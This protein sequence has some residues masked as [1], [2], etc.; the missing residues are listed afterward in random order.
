MTEFF[1]ATVNGLTTG[2]V[3]F[4]VAVGLTLVFGIGGVLN[5][6]HGAVFA[7]GAYVM[8][9]VLSRNESTMVMF[10]LAA[11]AA[12]LVAGLL[13]LVAE[14]LI[15]RRMYHLRHEYML[16]GTYALLLILDG[17]IELIWGPNPHS[18]TAP[19]ALRGAVTVPGV[20]INVPIFS[21]F[22]IVVALLTLL[23]L[24]WWMQ[25]TSF[26]RIAKAA[27]QDREATLALGV[28]VP[29]VM[30]GIFVLGSVLAGLAGAALAPN[31]AIFPALGHLFIIQAFAAIVMGG[32]GSVIGSWVAAVIL[33]L[34]DAYWFVL[35]PGVPQI[36]IFVALV[37]V[38]I[39]RPTGLMGAKS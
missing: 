24:Y 25:R 4:L 17:T 23:G 9:A 21:I 33:G 3:V 35:M 5:F 15:V 32:L 29:L 16:L 39:I 1:L 20:G 12:I 27:A 22:I 7:V 2:S 30:T 6:A 31:Q 28:N 38:L 13:G 19:Q 14:V 8:Y 36:G 37:I 11:L 34:A 26:G 10:V 18:T